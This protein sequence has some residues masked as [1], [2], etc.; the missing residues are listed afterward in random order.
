MV[1]QTVSNSL[2]PPLPT[3]SLTRNHQS[4]SDW[5]KSQPSRPQTGFLNFPIELRDM[6]YNNF[7]PSSTSIQASKYSKTVLTTT[8]TNLMATCRQVFAEGIKFKYETLFVSY[9][10][11]LIVDYML[12]RGAFNHLRKYGEH[13]KHVTV[14][15]S[16]KGS[17]A[18]CTASA[19]VSWPGILSHFVRL[20]QSCPHL[21]TLE[22][23]LKAAPHRLDQF[24]RDLAA[25]IKYNARDHENEPNYDQDQALYR[26]SMGAWSKEFNEFFFDGR[27]LKTH[28][29]SGVSTPK[30]VP[31]SLQ[32]KLVG[33]GWTEHYYA[34]E[35]AYIAK[36]L[37]DYRKN[38]LKWEKGLQNNHKRLRLN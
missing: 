7:T 38:E 11:G 5:R 34:K 17:G 35:N 37:E 19:R 18:L 26:K 9:S 33:Y 22:Y 14:A 2:L 15:V 8:I 24:S 25:L 36:A 32:I 23:L 6:V 30:T 21:V 28:L 10:E 16:P 3:R 20:A 13:V 27:F 1:A 29:G 31:D 12:P 4:L